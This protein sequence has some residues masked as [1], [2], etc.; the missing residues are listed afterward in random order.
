MRYSDIPTSYVL[1]DPEAPVIKPKSKTKGR[2]IT[3]TDDQEQWMREHYATTLNQE[4]ADHLGVSMR[5]MIRLA[6]RLGLEKDPDWLHGVFMERQA[7][8]AAANRGEGNA[9]TRNLIEHGKPYRFKKGVTPLERNGP[10]KEAQRIA[11]SA[12]TRRETIRKERMRVNWG[13]PQETKLKVTRNQ[14]A[15]ATRNYLKKLGYIVVGRGTMVIFFNS[16]TKRAPI[17]EA[18]AK[19]RGFTFILLHEGNVE[20]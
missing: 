14:P 15:C 16:K 13:L 17:A 20:Y 9:G 5:T 6:R 12:A 4:C 7:M 1:Y 2:K 11:K 3:F 10:E 18:N 8:M 19:K